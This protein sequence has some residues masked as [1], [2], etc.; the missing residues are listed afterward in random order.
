MNNYIDKD[1]KYIWHPCSQMKDY[2]EFPPKVIE[3]GEGCYLYDIEGN[4][5]LDC[6]SS[7]WT[8]LFGHSNKRINNALKKQ[9]DQIE[10]VIFA[11]F[12]NKPA[13]ELAEKLVKI[14][15]KKLEKVYFS[16]NGSSAVEIALKMSF[17][18]HQH[19]GNSKKTRFIAISDAYHGET[20]GALSVCDLDL[21]NKIYKPLLLNTLRVKGPDCYRCIY[22]KSRQYCSAECFEHMEKALKANH[23]NLCGIIIEPMVQGAAG[24]KIYSLIYLKKLREACNRYNIHLIA[25]EIAVGFGRTGKMFACEY[26]EISP[27]IMC[28]S[29]GIS[30]GYMPMSVIM[31]SENIYD[32]FY[33]EYKEL[34]AF[35]HSHT[36]AG[37]A[38]A[39]AIALENLKIF[40]EEHIIENN[41]EK[42]ELIKKLTEQL[43]KDHPY[44][45]EV[46]S[47]GMITAIELVKDKKTK[48]SFY[49][50]ER[51]GY[52]IYKIA[53]KKGLLL[54][55]IGNVLYF[56]PPYVINKNDIEFMVNTCF[57]SINEYFHRYIN[58]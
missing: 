14:T 49:W 57:E 33:G 45:G 28:L 7:W 8:N 52:E 22:G 43:S 3:R 31:A 21:Y 54:R 27:D 53:L 38:M 36:Y 9:I 47:I 10:H 30:A 42:G 12:S 4:R 35:L 44:V 2:E 16:D 11:N 46:R 48:E 41:K 40:E 29:K 34:K 26:G 39:C 18:Y 17:H 15:P 6:I 56:I 5:Y 51:V 1:L 25:D 20:L 50:Q 37:N 55:P 24:M 58:L 23:E 32:V 19:K 13:I